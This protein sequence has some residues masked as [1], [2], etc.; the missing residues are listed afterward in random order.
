MFGVRTTSLGDGRPTTFA[1]ALAYLPQSSAKRKTMLG[2]LT[3]SAPAAAHAQRNNV[4]SETPIFVMVHLRLS[5]ALVPSDPTVRCCKRPLPQWPWG[6]GWIAPVRSVRIPVP[7]GIAME[8]TTIDA[9]CGAIA[10]S[11]LLT[12]DQLREL[13]PQWRQADGPG[14]S[15]GPERF[16]QWLVQHGDLTQF[17]ADR[18]A[19]GYTTGY[20]LHTYKLVDRIGQGR[21]AGIYKAEHTLGQVVALKVLPPSRAKEPL[22]IGRFKREARLALK[23]KHPNV[24]RAFQ[25]GY[26]AGL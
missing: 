10:K 6:L 21:M 11:Q 14:G 5:S 8:I 12:H 19:K 20:F 25:V 15:T 16:L 23:L 13:I 4:K 1:Y 3:G 2:R 18:V 26:E 24:V 9:L 7:K 22:G 17:Q